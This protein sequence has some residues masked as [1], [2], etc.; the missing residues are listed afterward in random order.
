MTRVFIIEP[1]RES[2]NVSPAAEYGE[3]VYVFGP[4]ERRCSAFDTTKFGAA[5]LNK[6]STLRYDPEADLLCVVGSMVT[7][8]VSIAS[9][10][11]AHACFSLLLF[12]SVHGT[13]VKTTFK[14]DETLAV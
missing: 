14:R 6:L 2:L 13:Y 7:V 10:A 5:L 12:N 4:N 1:P 11:H 3:L 8:A 9:V